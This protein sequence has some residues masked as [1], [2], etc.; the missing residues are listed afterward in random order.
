MVLLLGHCEI[1][2]KTID[3]GQLAIDD[4]GTD[5]ASDGGEHFGGKSVHE[6]M[7][8]ARML[9]LLQSLCWFLGGFHRRAKEQPGLAVPQEEAGIQRQLKSLCWF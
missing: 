6:K 2:G 5:G 9:W 3:E 7:G 1:D 4:G 8:E